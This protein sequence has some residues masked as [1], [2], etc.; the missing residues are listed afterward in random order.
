MSRPAVRASEPVPAGF[1]LSMDAY[2]R[3]LNET[4]LFGGSPARILRLSPAGI[5]AWD[6]LRIGPVSTRAG[7][8]LARRL[9]DAGLAHPRPPRLTGKPDVTVIIPVQDRA[10]MLAR[11]LEALGDR[12]PVVV[13]DD[14]SRW[15]EL[16]AHVAQAHGA[17]VVPRFNGGAAAARNSGLARVTS[18]LVAFLDSDCVPPPDWIDDLAAHFADPLV[19]AVAPRVVAIPAD[20]PVGLYNAACGSLDLG[21]AEG[22][23]APGTRISYVPTAALLARR[24]ALAHVAGIGEVF[25]PAL[26]CGEDVDLIWR[27]DEAGWRIRYEPAVQV[28][29]TEPDTWDALL[30]RRFRYGTSA[31][32]LAVRHPDAI[33]PLALH[34]WPTVTVLGMLAGRPEVA[35]A[36]FATGVLTMAATLRR[37]EI[38]TAGVVPA[39]A[40]ATHQ[41]WLGIG[42]YVTQFG[43]PVLAAALVAP[44]GRTPA[45]RWLRRAAAASLLLAPPLT[46][47][48]EKRPGLS[49][50]RFVAARIADDVCYGAGVWTGAIRSRT[51]LPVRPVLVGR[52]VRIEP[53]P[54]A[55]RAR[56][57][58]G[59]GHA[60]GGAQ[61]ANGPEPANGRRAANG[62]HTPTDRPAQGSDNG[63]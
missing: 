32:P 58:P 2:T 4:L 1:R 38:P 44:G 25:D 21:G 12:Y 29:H 30:S 51:A 7:G 63:E 49:P 20:S 50:A 41:T 36:G 53:R 15:P 52:P 46:E 27:L 43:S 6:E 26:R 62:R 57:A 19:A 22:R 47:W 55:A 13:V 23:V 40:R 54:L 8:M 18:E 34:P 45:R 14:G 28:Q 3:Q 11:A 37:N 60:R 17:Q 33:A 42:R 24:A 31:G 5:R 16:V 10:V 59:A 9:T 56:Q 35:G 48:A 39:I 61:P